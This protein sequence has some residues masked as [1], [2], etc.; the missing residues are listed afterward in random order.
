MK[1]KIETKFITPFDYENVKVEGEWGRDR[2]MDFI[3]GVSDLAIPVY[4][5]VEIPD[6]AI[7]VSIETERMRSKFNQEPYSMRICRLLYLVPVDSKEVQ[8]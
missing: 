2:S 3:T 1:Y 8:P 6:G 5:E 4:P 7:C